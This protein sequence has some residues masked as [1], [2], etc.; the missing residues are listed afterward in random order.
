[1]RFPKFLSGVVAGLV[2]MP[3]TVAAEELHALYFPEQ[4]RT[5]GILLYP[6][7]QKSDVPEA[8]LNGRF[9]IDRQERSVG[10]AVQMFTSYRKMMILL[11]SAACVDEVRS[12]IER[13]GLDPATFEF[14]AMQ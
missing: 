5:G 7:L 12:E 13:L 2:I 3:A 1:M 14:V 8:F 6:C 10:E 4:D 9:K 11:T